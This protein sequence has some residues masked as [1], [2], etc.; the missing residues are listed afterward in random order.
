MPILKSKNKTVY[1]KVTIWYD[2][3]SKLFGDNLSPL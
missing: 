3:D 2:D 1:N